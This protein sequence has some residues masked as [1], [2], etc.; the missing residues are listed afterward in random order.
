MLF[1]Q[2]QSHFFKLHR[3]PPCLGISYP[4]QAETETAPKKKGRGK[5]GKAGETNR[6]TAD[7]VDLA[8]ASDVNLRTTVQFMVSNDIFLNLMDLP[9]VLFF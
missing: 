8:M 3:S 6:S 4:G 1:Q 9:N 7:I 2:K 5:G